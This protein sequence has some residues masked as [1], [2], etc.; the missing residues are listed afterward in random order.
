VRTSL[1][2]ALGLRD[3]MHRAAVLSQYRALLRAAASAPAPS[4]RAELT[5]HVKSN[6]RSAAARVGPSALDRKAALAEGAKQLTL[7]RSY[8]GTSKVGEVAAAAAGGA[9]PALDDTNSWVG[10]G[11]EYD[12]RGRV[13]SKWPWASN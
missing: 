13:G 7:L 10:T 6:F 2:G 8:V 5:A 11:E 9:V 4:T 1:R 3:W 12:I